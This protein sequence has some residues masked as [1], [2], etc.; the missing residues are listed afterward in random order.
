MLYP[1]SDFAE[2]ENGDENFELSATDDEYYPYEIDDADGMLYC[3]SK[4]NIPIVFTG[5]SILIL[6]CYYIYPINTHII[7]YQ[8]KQVM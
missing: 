3:T 4:K 6:T 5:Y 1:N 8:A 7:L 2:T